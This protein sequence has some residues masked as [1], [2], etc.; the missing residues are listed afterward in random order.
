MKKRTIL[1][2]AVI[3]MTMTSFNP[4]CNGEVTISGNGP[5][6]IQHPTQCGG[7]R[8][9]YAKKWKALFHLWFHPQDQCISLICPN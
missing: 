7:T 9:I 5:Y 4:P 1:L 3:V 2:L 6:L 8:L